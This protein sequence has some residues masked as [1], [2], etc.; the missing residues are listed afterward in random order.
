MRALIFRPLH[1]S[2]RGH[3]L[4]QLERTRVSD[5]LVLRQ[6]FVD[7]AYGRGAARPEDLK[8][9]EFGRGGVEFRFLLHGA[10]ATTKS[11]VVST[12]TFVVEGGLRRRT[13]LAPDRGLLMRC[14]AA[15]Q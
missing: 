3:D 7:L 11:F 10:E 4:Q 13:Y 1:D 8:D 5:V 12:K 2:L 14:H 15:L 9:L 6:D